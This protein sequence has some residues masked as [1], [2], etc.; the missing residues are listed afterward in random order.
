MLESPT[1]AAPYK[2]VEEIDFQLAHYGRLMK[3]AGKRDRPKVRRKLNQILDERLRL[4]DGI[5]LDGE[6][7][8]L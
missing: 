6:L 7:S 8:G 2:T 4:T 1:V 5:P 3:F